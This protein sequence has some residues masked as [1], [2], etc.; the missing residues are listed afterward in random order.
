MVKIKK[1]KIRHRR[2]RALPL[3]RKAGS[4][5]KALKFVLLFILV[6][7][8]GAGIV[9]FQY[10]FADSDYFK[11][12][13]VEAKLLDGNGSL[14]RLPMDDVGA[15]E[16][17]GVNIF[18]VDLSRIKQDVEASHPEF[19]DVVITRALPNRLIVQAKKRVPVL[20]I[21]SDRFYFVD[22]EGVVLPDPR[23]FP[24]EDMPTVSGL[25]LNLAKMRGEEAMQVHPALVLI[26]AASNISQLARYKL[27]TIDLSDPRNISFFLDAGNVEIKIGDSEFD[28]R[29]NVLV[30]VLE[31]LDTDI[32][33]IKYIDLRFEDPIVGPK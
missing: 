17:I 28:K 21:R 19:K 8:A 12:K 29:L 1:Q 24:E 27:K 33:R 30:T 3:V 31:Q 2:K 25:R 14:Q 15:R 32:N 7:A 6:S 26:K 23:N 11:I 16:V 18:A 22:E 13:R 4:S 9:R 20:Q 5:R 10:M